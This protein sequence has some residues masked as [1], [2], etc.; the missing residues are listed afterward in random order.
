MATKRSDKL[1]AEMLGEEHVIT[2][3]EL[4][5]PDLKSS[6]FGGY[7]KTETDA[8][9]ARAADAI[10]SMADQVRLLREANLALNERLEE[11]REMEST[12]RSALTSSQKFSEEIVESAR[13]EADAIISEAKAERA[14]I[15][16]D[17][18][19]VPDA[20]REEIRMLG[21]QRGRLQRDLQAVIEAHRKLIEAANIGDAP[22]NIGQDAGA[23]GDS[24]VEL[25]GAD[26]DST[27]N[28]DE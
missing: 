24:Y 15:A 3:S 27:E 26:E 10:E 4:A 17:R 16:A 6:F 25:P 5:S 11:H 18:H 7:N 1:L 21:E 2:P 14:G 28:E 8:L 12:L 13:R 9:L 19:K 23:E 20:L 22:D